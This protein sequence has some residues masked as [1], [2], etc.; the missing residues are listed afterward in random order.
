MNKIRYKEGKSYYIRNLIIF[1]KNL[2]ILMNIKKVKDKV[3]KHKDN[4][5]LLDGF[6][7]FA[8][9]PTSMSAGYG[10]KE[11]YSYIRDNLKATYDLNDSEVSEQVDLL[12]NE[13]DDLL[14]LKEDKYSIYKI[15]E[16]IKDE[17]SKEPYIE[18]FKNYIK[19]RLNKFDKDIENFLYIYKNSLIRNFPCL[20][21][22]FNA[23]YGNRISISK[24][25]NLGILKSL[26]WISSGTSPPEETP[27]LLPFL[28][29]IID[30][31]LRGFFDKLKKFVGLKPWNPKKP[32]V[33]QK[34]NNLTENHKYKTLEF[35]E[36][37]YEGDKICTLT[38]SEYQ[39]IQKMEGIIG[40]YKSYDSE[41]TY[42]CISFLIK[43]ELY[44]R[45]DEYRKNRLKEMTQKLIEILEFEIKNGDLPSK[46][47]MIRELNLHIDEIEKYQNILNE[48]PYNEFSEDQDIK[49]KATDAIKEFENLLKDLNFDIITASKV[50]N[51][52]KTEKLIDEVYR[53]PNNETTLSI[54]PKDKDIKNNEYICSNCG[55]P[56]R[57][58]ENP[59]YCP[60]CGS[61]V[62]RN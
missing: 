58:R 39:N 51:Y 14:K 18:K 48:F 53:I 56:L 46:K 36:G 57:D 23:I 3:Q 15:R 35:L 16:I 59:D 61:K 9:N 13:I 25:K 32:D 12:R 44:N 6:L 41:R 52:L 8:L 43:D 26:Y 62:S 38:F 47:E 22:Q 10:I 24:L 40:I 2:G 50:L 34:I 19:K 31:L 7:Q 49:N 42:A 45:I 29:D 28:D 11:K 30:D 4:L 21:V 5:I 37:L 17:I 27:K 60:Y 1:I 20:C 33:K 54:Q 55:I